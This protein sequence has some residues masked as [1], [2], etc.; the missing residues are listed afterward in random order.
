MHEQFEVERFEWQAPDRLEVAGR[1]HGLQKPPAETPVLVVSGGGV[2]H[3]LNAVEESPVGEGEI[4][5]AQFL[6][7]EAPVGVE[8]AALELGPDIVV[9]L[10]P[11]GTATALLR[12]RRASAGDV[13]LQTEL[14]AAE[15]EMQ[16]LRSALERTEAELDRARSDVEAERSGRAADAERFREGLAQV[17]ASA[18]EAVAAAEAEVE[19][20][21]QRMSAVQGVGREAGELRADAQRLLQRVTKLVDVLDDGK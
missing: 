5:R 12:P 10:P 16:E 1:F 19:R 13:G 3:R 8:A 20:L 7:H 17:R 18:E 11:P 2:D 9:D 14:L 4:W 21:Q 6:W 15:Q